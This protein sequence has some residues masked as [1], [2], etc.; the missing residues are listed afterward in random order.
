MP[1][2][3]AA[4]E[5]GVDGFSGVVGSS[6]VDVPV[7]GISTAAFL[8]PHTLHSSCLEPFSVSVAALSTTHS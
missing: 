3:P 2:S 4:G 6:G 8:S 7:A 5:S 1:L